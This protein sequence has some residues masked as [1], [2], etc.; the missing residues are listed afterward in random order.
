MFDFAMEHPICTVCIVYIIC[1]AIC[2]S[3]QALAGCKRK[4]IEINGK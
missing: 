3:T 2:L 4:K 1:D